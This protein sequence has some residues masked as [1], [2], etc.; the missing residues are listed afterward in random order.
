[1][2]DAGLIWSPVHA[3][4]KEVSKGTT[5]FYT[6]PTISSAQT[7]QGAHPTLFHIS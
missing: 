4:E 2:M 3:V 7:I 6:H 1:M 5:K